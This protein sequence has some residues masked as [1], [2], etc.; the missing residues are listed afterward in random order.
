MHAE[1]NCAGLRGLR[2]SALVGCIVC[3]L[4]LA[5]GAAAGGTNGGGFVE[6]VYTL[7]VTPAGSG[8]GTVTSL[9]AGIDC[10]STCS[11]DFAA[12]TLVTL[13]ATAASGS[14]FAGW[15]GADCSGTGNCQV[16]LTMA[17]SVT[18]TFDQACVVPK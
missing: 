4:V 8:S 15:S 6:T 3:V 12:G 14:T 13:T 2:R 16:T 7:S 18:A 11:Y 9:P 10:G 5:P 17:E 1:S